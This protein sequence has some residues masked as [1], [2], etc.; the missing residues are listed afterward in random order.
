[1]SPFS[2]RPTPLC[3]LQEAVF[4]LTSAPRITEMEL[5]APN[6]FFQPAQPCFQH[7]DLL[8]TAGVTPRCLF[9]DPHL[10]GP[11]QGLSPMGT[12]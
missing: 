4:L 6:G 11:P 2:R 7:I 1:M 9:A 5:L 10:L 3:S 12:G 8:V